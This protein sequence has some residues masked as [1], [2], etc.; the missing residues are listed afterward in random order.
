M[1]CVPSTPQVLGYLVNHSDNSHNVYVIIIH[2]Q[3][4]FVVLLL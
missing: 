3:H 4:Y 2:S 1:V